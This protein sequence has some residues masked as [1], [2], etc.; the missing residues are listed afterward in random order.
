MNRSEMAQIVEDFIDN[1]LC[2]YDPEELEEAAEQL[3]T[4]FNDCLD[5]SIV[6]QKTLEASL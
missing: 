2:E 4:V 6:L 3:R 1:I 5:S